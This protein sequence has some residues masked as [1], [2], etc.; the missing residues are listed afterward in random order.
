MP[1]VKVNQLKVGDLITEDVITDLGNLLLPKGIRVDKKEIEILQDFLIKE[2]HIQKDESAAS[3]KLF[4]EVN[5][6]ASSEVMEAEN[7]ESSSVG[8]EKEYEMMFSIMSRAMKQIGGGEIPLL[9][10]RKQLLQLINKI[11][12]YNVLT[13]TPP[14]ARLED[15]LIHNSITV[16]LT[17]YLLGKWSGYESKDLIPLALAGL[18]HDI[19]N[20]KVDHNLLY[21]PGKLSQEELQEVK[22]HTV[23]GYNLLKPIAGI[24]EGIK[25]TA[26]QH[27]ERVDGSGYPLGLKAEKIHPYAKV[28][29]VADIY[30]SMSSHRSYKEAASPY[31]VLDQLFNDS[32]DKL[33]P[34]LVQT[35]IQKVTQFHNGTVVKLSNDCVGEI[36]F[37]D[38]N[39]PTRPWVKVNGTIINLDQERQLYIKE[40]INVM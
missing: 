40:V 19:G 1:Q 6:G 30:H 18:F 28:V 26:L 36:I 23:Y 21:K 13:F 39:S 22:Q 16:A 12:E 10:I 4:E 20:V 24:N 2:V 11:D 3:D 35:F 31:L 27:H 32:F 15:Y 38:R 33:D 9:D 7:H 37:S 14:K 25:L 34:V 29:A 5:N 17:S 8:F